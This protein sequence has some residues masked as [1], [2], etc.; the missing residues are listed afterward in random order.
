MFDSVL[1]HDHP[2]V[3]EESTWIAAGS[4]LTQL[5]W[6]YLLGRIT[7]TSDDL[8]TAM[9]NLPWMFG[10]V[11]VIA[12]VLLSSPSS[13][14]RP[15]SPSL[16]G[17]AVPTSTTVHHLVRAGIQGGLLATLFLLRMCMLHFCGL[18]FASLV[19]S[20]SYCLA[21]PLSKALRSTHAPVHGIMAIAGGYALALVFP[22]II[23]TSSSSSSTGPSLLFHLSLFAA[24]V[25]LQHMY[26]SLQPSQPCQTTTNVTILTHTVVVYV[27]AAMVTALASHCLIPSPS[28]HLPP[29]EQPQSHGVGSI[30][31]L[32]VVGILSILLPATTFQD[33]DMDSR[34]A[35][36][37]VSV[38]LAVQFPLALVTSWLPGGSMTN[39]WHMVVHAIVSWTALSS[40]AWG[41]WLYLSTLHK[42]AA[43][44][45]SAA[46]SSIL[47][48]WHALA[49]AT[50]KILLF[51]TGNIVYMFVEF[52]VGYMTNSLGLLSDAGH[53][54]FDNGALVI[55]LGASLAATWPRTARFPYGFDRIQVLSGFV[56]SLLLLV[57]AIHFMLEAIDRVLDPPTITTDHLLLTSVGGLVMNGVGLVWFHDLAHG[58][59]HGDGSDGG[60]MSKDANLVGVYLHVLADTMGSVG[61]IMSSVC[62]DWFGWYIMD[63]VCSGFI[64]VVIVLSTL[65][66]LRDTMAQLMQ[67][68]SSSSAAAVELARQR[69]A[70]LPFV[71]HV[72]QV[73][74]WSHAGNL[75][76]TMHVVVLENVGGAVTR[77]RH[78]IAQAVHVHQLTV[79]VTHVTEPLDSDQIS[80][81][82]HH[83][84]SS[85]H[86]HG[87]SH[88]THGGCAHH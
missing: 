53:M 24:S 54:L 12:A 77:I 15:S 9:G 83:G 78:V 38:R 16:K 80:D 74:A 66:L 17:K 42:P 84:S 34:Q 50:Q 72:D 69:V 62:I 36:W 32:I 76:V 21:E 26:R 23:S 43:L 68:I 48:T 58:H 40:I 44:L 81:H 25:A 11:G 1:F 73:H 2:P 18:Q 85:D 28:I 49:P 3:P 88:S 13:S 79:Q 60:C 10:V 41:W 5:T 29:L 39:T 86:H 4:A 31:S 22:C 65:P 67:G 30:M 19:E 64:S 57:M 75:V 71:H 37:N 63:P 47:V 52:A 59:S 35:H 56:N 14:F 20:A 27:T 8:T 33:D 45:P 51:L 7:F 46:T 87:H 61:V 82:H 6:L 70:Q 55:G